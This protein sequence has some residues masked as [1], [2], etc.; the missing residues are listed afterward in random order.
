MWPSGRVYS[1][2]DKAYQ[3]EPKQVKKRVARNKAR[4]RMTKKVGKAALAGKDVWHKKSLESGWKTTVKN[5]KVQAKKTDRA[6]KS[7]IKKKR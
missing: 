2:Y 3:A 4:R 5:I 6:D 1:A 7:M